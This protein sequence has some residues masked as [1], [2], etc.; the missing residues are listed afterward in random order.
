[1][2]SAVSYLVQRLGGSE[3][4]VLQGPRRAAVSRTYGGSSGSPVALRLK[5]M[6]PPNLCL[7]S[8]TG[9]TGGASNG[10]DTAASAR[11]ILG[12]ARGYVRG[13]AGLASHLKKVHH[14]CGLRQCHGASKAE[15]VKLQPDWLEQFQKYVFGLEKL[16]SLCLP[17]WTGS[18]EH[19]IANRSRRWHR[20]AERGH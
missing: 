14:C 20:G 3:R 5:R 7:V 1:M 15:F 9:I 10:V 16:P 6:T 4:V 17:R 13:V 8:W 11:K 18:R 2:R 19:H 12:H